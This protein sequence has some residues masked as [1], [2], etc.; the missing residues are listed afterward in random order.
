MRSST[1]VFAPIAL[2]TF[3]ATVVSCTSGSPGSEFNFVEATIDDA[4]SA[5]RSGDMTCSGIVQGYL[6]RIELY[7]KSSGLNA[8][9]VT[10]P[11]AMAE[12]QVIDRSYSA[13]E[14]L[15]PL[16]CAPVLLKDKY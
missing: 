12:A 7:D 3:L 11:K 1:I 10:N 8:I 9:I 2:A 13:G 14:T 15:G 16:F 4:Q 6:D 5:I